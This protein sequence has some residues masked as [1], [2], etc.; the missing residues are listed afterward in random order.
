MSWSLCACTQ[1]KFCLC[2]PMEQI[3]IYYH[4]Q[5][6]LLPCTDNIHLVQEGI[7]WWDS[8]LAMEMVILFRL[9][10]WWLHPAVLHQNTHLQ[11][12]IQWWDSEQVGQMAILFRLSQWLHPAVLYQNT[13][14]KKKA[15][16]YCHAGQPLKIG[17]WLQNPMTNNK[18]R[19]GS[20]LSVA[21]DNWQLDTRGPL[22]ISFPW[23]Q[24]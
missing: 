12:G 19:A 9:S 6:I 11:E 22:M 16:V 5:S 1:A 24:H 3:L 2:A 8:E 7:Q 15:Y 17:R 18:N 23:A 20:N 10:Q 4:S 14:L 21:E 13:H